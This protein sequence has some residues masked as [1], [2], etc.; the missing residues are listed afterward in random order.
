LKM[1]G[2]VLSKILG[3]NVKPGERKQHGLQSAKEKQP[4]D[5]NV[6]VEKKTGAEDKRGGEP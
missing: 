3:A 5:P 2:Q 4:H 1:G 6:F